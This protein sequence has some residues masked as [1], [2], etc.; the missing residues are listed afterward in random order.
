MRSPTIACLTYKFFQLIIH[1]LGTYCSA[2][3]SIYT[4][5][6]T[7]IKNWKQH[8]CLKKLL[9]TD[10]VAVLSSWTGAHLIGNYFWITNNNCVCSS[11]RN[12]L[13][14]SYVSTGCWCCNALKR[15]AVISHKDQMYRDARENSGAKTIN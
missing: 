14:K 8:N 13:H 15:L 9:T 5:L 11:C 2:E 1:L 4:Q 7:N 6:I 10:S 3:E 12:N